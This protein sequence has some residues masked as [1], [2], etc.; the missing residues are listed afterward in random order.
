MLIQNLSNLAQ[1]QAPQHVSNG[2]PISVVPTSGVAVELPKIAAQ[3]VAEPQPST[4][5][6]KSALDNINQM[7]KQSDKGIEFSLDDST[8]KSVIKVVDPTTGDVIRQFPSEDA[9]AIT[10]SIDRIQQGLLLKQKA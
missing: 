2:E 9:L 1:T 7:L 6:L 3:P 10:R 4:T 5:Q 8:N